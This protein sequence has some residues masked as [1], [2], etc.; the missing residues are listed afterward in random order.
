MTSETDKKAL[1]GQLRIDRAADERAGIPRSWWL[2]AG[3]AA[4]VLALA[5]GGALI[6]FG[7]QR[8]EV[9]AAT[10]EPP[11]QGGGATAILQ[12]TGYVTARREATV[13][14]QITGTLTQVLI[15]E[16]DRVKEGQ[17]LARLD[18]TAQQ[19]ALAQARRQLE[20]E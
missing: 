15:E 1:L 2:A 10:A 5:A 19:A 11:A 7:G 14:T 3:M 16:G 20:N 17:I 12:A 13:S 8:V 6:L 4:V 9:E 18:G